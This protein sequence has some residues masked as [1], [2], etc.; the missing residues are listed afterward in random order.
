MTTWTILCDFD[1]TISTCDV[2]DALLERF[3]RPGWEVLEEEWRLGR[4]GSR[5]CLEGQVA[6]IDAS[7]QEL[8]ALVDGIGIDAAFPAFVAAARA[9]GAD[10]VVVSDGLDGVIGRILRKHGLGDLPV[11]ANRLLQIGPRAWRAEFPN[12]AVACRSGSGNC[13]CACAHGQ[14]ETQ[15]RTLL[16]GDGRSDFCAAGSVD[17]VFA[18]DRLLEH[19]RQVRLPHVAIAG[20]E[21]AIGLLPGLLDGT[22]APAPLPPEPISHRELIAND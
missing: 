1:G 12:A 21:D 4:I 14:R 3:A 2:T 9:A 10:V 16:V 6:L 18:K 20:F 7:A 15:R 22:L 19:C 5:Q 17:F 13:K 11:V 8:T